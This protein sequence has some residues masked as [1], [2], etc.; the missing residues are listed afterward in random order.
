MLNPGFAK[1]VYLDEMG[2][3]VRDVLFQFVVL[4]D[5]GNSYNFGIIHGGAIYCKETDLG[6]MCTIQDKVNAENLKKRAKDSQVE[7]EKTKL[8]PVL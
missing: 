3:F 2:S 7:E 8:P 5:D 1:T 6:Q 4:T